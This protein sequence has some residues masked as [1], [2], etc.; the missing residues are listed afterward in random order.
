MNNVMH[1][2]L[3]YLSIYFCLTCFGLSFSPSSEAGIKLR[4]K[5]MAAGYGVSARALIPYPGDLN[6]CRNYTPTS[7]EGLKESLKHVRQK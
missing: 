2:F 5:F 6:H 4:Q 3:I 7:E 1:K